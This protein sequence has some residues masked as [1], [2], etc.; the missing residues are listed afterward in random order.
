MKIACLYLTHNNSEC[1]FNLQTLIK[2]IN[3]YKEHQIDL[4]IYN[5]NEKLNDIIYDN[6]YCEFTY[7]NLQEKL[8]YIYMFGDTLKYI[9][10]CHLPVIDL[11]LSHK[12]YDKFIFYEDD[13]SYVGN[14]NMFNLFDFN[15]DFMFQ[16]KRNLEM[17][18]WWYIANER[19]NLQLTP[20]SGLLNIYMLSS[21]VI[22]KIY[23]FMNEGNFA[24]H[25]YL[26]NS[27]IMEN[28]EK[29]NWQIGYLK[30]NNEFNVY[31]NQFNYTG[32]HFIH[33]IKNIQQLQ[34]YKRQ[35]H[36]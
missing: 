1:L 32:T 30:E 28:Y 11:Y 12:E 19:H 4:Y 6:N 21:D 27:Y 7:K 15:I 36:K 24:H 5:N 23:D 10:N 8:N 31:T 9:G 33:P 2:H 26:I 35:L 3:S 14:I 34:L 25:E 29:Y 13:V 17:T 18:W 20:Y 16:N 22:Q